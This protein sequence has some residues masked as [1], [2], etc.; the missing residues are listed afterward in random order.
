MIYTRNIFRCTV[1]IMNL[2]IQ[3]KQCR[4]FA[5]K[6]WAVNYPRNLVLYLS[7]GISCATK[8]NPHEDIQHPPVFLSM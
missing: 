1:V 4:K 3:D 2:L 5:G 8:F 6:L 7:D